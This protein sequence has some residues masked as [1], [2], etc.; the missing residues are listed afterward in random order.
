MQCDH[1]VWIY[2]RAAGGGRISH[3]ETT[4]LYCVADETSIWTIYCNIPILQLNRL[5]QLMEVRGNC[6]QYKT[7]KLK[8]KVDLH[9]KALFAAML[10]HLVIFLYH[11]HS[12]KSPTFHTFPSPILLMAS[13]FSIVPEGHCQQPL[14]PGPRCMPSLPLAPS[15]QGRPDTDISCE[16]TCGTVGILGVCSFYLIDL[17]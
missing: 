15:S 2:G 7:G 11:F 17:L 9:L 12:W 14:L 3:A 10:Y 16:F 13:P 1:N 5:N 6:K 8:V 4:F